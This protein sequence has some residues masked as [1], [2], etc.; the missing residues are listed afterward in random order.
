[1]ITWGRTF[2]T[3]SYTDDRVRAKIARSYTRAESFEFS[4]WIY[5]LFCHFPG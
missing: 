2:R 1:M 5:Y 4:I 3:L